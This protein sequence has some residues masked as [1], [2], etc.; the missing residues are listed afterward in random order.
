MVRYATHSDVTARPLRA[1]PALPARVGELFERPRKGPL[2]GRESGG[3]ATPDAAVQSAPVTAAAATG[4]T[5]FEGI[6]NLDGVL[7]PDPN[8]DIGPTQYVETVNLHLAVYN[9]NGTLAYG[10]VTINTLW[11]G[12]GGA[13]ETSNDGDPVVQYDQLANRWMISQFALPRF[14]RGPFYQCIAVSQTGDATGSYYRYQFLVSNNKLN[15]YPK[16]GVWPDAYYMSIN[17]FSCKFIGCSWAGAGAIAFER[18]AMLSGQAARMVY[19]DLYSTDPNLGGMLPSDLDGNT[20]PP[21]GAANIFA[22]M[23]DDAWGYSLDQLQLWGFHVDWADPATSTFTRTTTMGVSA[24]DSDMCGYARNCIPQ[25]G[26]TKLDALSDRLM[27][28]LAYRNFGD[29]QALVVN[30]TVDAGADKAGVRWYELRNGGAG[31]GVAQQSTFSPD[32]ANRWVASAAMNG[33][34]DIAIA[35]SVSSGSVSPSIRAAGRATSDP[36]NTLGSVITLKAGSGYQTHSSGRWGDYSM[37]AVDPLDDCTFWYAGEYTAGVSSAGWHTFIGSFTIS[38]CSSTPTAPV[39]NFSATPTS[40]VAPLSVQFT[41][42]S[43]G[44]PTSWSWTFGDGGTSTLQ[45][46]SHTYSAAGS[47]TVTLTATN[48]VGSDGET[49][50]AYINV[51]APSPIS[52]TVSGYK[53]KGVQKADLTWSGASGANVDVYRNGVKTTT[54]NAGSFTDNINQ[55]GSGSYT[56]RVCQEGSTTVCSNEVT[57]TF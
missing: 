45:N 56:Y 55:R 24:F 17:Q 57:I 20:P 27:Y 3:T 15:D 13:C 16:F 44:A 52:L 22:Q 33:A 18:D 1:L 36:A 39:A 4:G 6:G 21:T 49:K 8:G 42:T 50:V 43:S 31:W 47:Y 35:Y 54:A 28:R 14:P 7:P 25:P 10:P 37:L 34:G 40:G 19:F 29:H 51:S 41:D 48:G 46:P 30:H 9:R 5:N 23:D 2:P 38:S 53:V 32:D 26:G 11:Q 12:F